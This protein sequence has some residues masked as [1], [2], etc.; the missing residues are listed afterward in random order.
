MPV[1]IRINVCNCSTFVHWIEW[2]KM[3]FCD[4]CTS[5]KMKRFIQLYSYKHKHAKTKRYFQ[6]YAYKHIHPNKGIEPRNF[7]ISKMSYIYSNL[8]WI[9]KHV[10][11]SCIDS[12]LV[13]YSWCSGCEQHNCISIHIV[14]E[15]LHKVWIQLLEYR[16]NEAI[17]WLK[18]KVSGPEILKLLMEIRKEKPVIIY[19]MEII[20]LLSW[21]LMFE[22]DVFG[23]E[24]FQPSRW[25]VD[26]RKK[27]P[28][29]TKNNFT[30]CFLPTCHGYF[31]FHCFTNNMTIMY[32][33]LCK[34]PKPCVEHNIQEKTW[35]KSCIPIKKNEK[36]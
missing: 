13:F 20:H 17:K 2:K 23:T 12:I 34:F 36:M 32:H 21:C 7:S 16:T 35:S 31:M 15:N 9:S 5:L 10:N 14:V 26:S 8:L 19:H 4:V 1:T 30:S 29:Y 6:F 3:H 11:D 27:Y 18:F 22:T 25:N 28:D 24:I 33:V